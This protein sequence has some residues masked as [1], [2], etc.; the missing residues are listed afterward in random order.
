MTQDRDG[1]TTTSRIVA[2]IKARGLPHPRVVSWGVLS[3]IDSFHLEAL[4]MEIGER[5]RQLREAR[6]LSQGEIQKRTGLLRCYTSRVECGHTIP[7]LGTLQK[8]AKALDVEFYQ[9]FYSGSG[10]P[11]APEV[12]GQS[13]LAREERKLVEMFRQMSPSDKE[14]VLGLA[15]HATRRQRRRD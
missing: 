1:R 9:L 2:E 5:L 8:M 11:I 4:K 15:R 14:L 13:S 3:R 12:P 6:H 10:K 7:S